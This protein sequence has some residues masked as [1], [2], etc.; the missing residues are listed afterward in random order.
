MRERPARLVGEDARKL[1]QPELDLLGR[2]AVAREIR[3]ASPYLLWIRMLVQFVTQQSS[4]GRSDA[5]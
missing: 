3:G 2:L 5:L 1:L 4:A